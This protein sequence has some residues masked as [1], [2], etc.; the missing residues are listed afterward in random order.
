[1][2][3]FDDKPFTR[4]AL[5]KIKSL[6][7]ERSIKKCKEE[8]KKKVSFASEIDV[9][10]SE[11][12][13]E[14]IVSEV[15]PERESFNGD[16]DDRDD[17]IESDDETE[18]DPVR[19][20][21]NDDR[22]DCDDCDDVRDAAQTPK[23]DSEKTLTS[24]TKLFSQK[25]SILLFVYKYERNLL[26]NKNPDKLI[27]KLMKINEMDTDSVVDLFFASITK[28]Q[29]HSIYT[30]II[31]HQ[32]ITTNSYDGSKY[33]ICV[34]DK[35]LSKNFLSEYIYTLLNFFVEKKFC[36]ND[37]ILNIYRLNIN[38]AVG[39]K[40]NNFITE[41]ILENNVNYI[42][43]FGSDVLR[44]MYDISD[45]NFSKIFA[46]SIVIT[47]NNI[48]K[49]ILKYSDSIS[50]RKLYN[51]VL[52]I[53]SVYPNLKNNFF[54]KTMASIE[55]DF[56]DRL[57]I[58]AIFMNYAIE[59][60]EIGLLLCIFDSV[61]NIK[62]LQLLNSPL[63]TDLDMYLLKL[64]FISKSDNDQYESKK[65]LIDYIKLHGIESDIVFIVACMTENKSTIKFISKKIQITNKKCPICLKINQ[66]DIFLTDD[67]CI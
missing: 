27:K 45:S 63:I 8:D 26:K 47:S 36:K 37:D 57:R 54:K 29:I 43:Y 9:I 46:A 12:E 30:H 34:K 25:K 50:P 39:E 13:Y 62:L 23:N 3:K 21:S 42:T 1:M 61:T 49:I 52:K 32:L 33:I 17:C 48:I 41:I 6:A 11:Y 35:K 16:R 7:D 18:V 4:R 53:N 22:D 60:R 67:A 66:F 2:Y 55:L 10:F 56:W 28:Y 38:L 51:L 20:S 19:E 24:I 58:C 5:A 14:T 64:L 59:L 40:I 44:Y 15:D 31:N 65:I